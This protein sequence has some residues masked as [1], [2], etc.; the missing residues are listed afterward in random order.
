MGYNRVDKLFSECPP[1]DTAP[2]HGSI[3]CVTANECQIQ[4]DYGYILDSG[5]EAAFSTCHPPP[6][7]VESSPPGDPSTPAV[8]E[9]SVDLT[10]SAQC[11]RPVGVVVGGTNSARA[12]E[13]SVEIVAGDE[14]PNCAGKRLPDLP[15]KVRL[16]FVYLK[17][18][19]HLMAL[20]S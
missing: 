10:T 11:V 6:A 7:I 5:P 3:L 16:G 8:G 13:S 2:F 1:F 17:F 20:F 9:W 14:F 19:S 15:V 12:Y 18:L 4:C